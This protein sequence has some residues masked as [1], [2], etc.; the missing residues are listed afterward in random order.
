MRFGEGSTVTIDMAQP[1][2]PAVTGFINENGDLEIDGV[3]WTWKQGDPG[4]YRRKQTT[5]PGA[6]WYTLTFESDGSVGRHYY[7]METMN[8]IH[9]GSGSWTAVG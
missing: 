4:D 5:Q 8:Q 2:E 3:I 6:G 7:P 9:T 1:D